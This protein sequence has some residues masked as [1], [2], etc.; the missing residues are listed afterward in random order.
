MVRLVTTAADRVAPWR[1]MGT[2]LREWRLAHG[3][4]VGVALPVEDAG[5]LLPEELA[6]AATL[7]EVR[8]RSWV[9]GRVAMRLTLTRLGLAAPPIT[10]DDRGAPVL[11]AGMV[12]SISHKEDLAVALVAA[13]DRDGAKIGVDVEKDEPRRLDI[14]RK[15]LRDEELAELARMPEHA[16]GSEVLLR[17]S[18]KEAL[19]K[20]LDPFVRRYV[21]FR[22]VAITPLAGGTSRVAWDL[23]EGE[24]PFHADVRWMREGDLILTTARVWPGSP[25]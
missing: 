18:A 17:F 1:P 19:Y 22:E 2:A 13:G 20:A 23:T 25:R 4:S 8:R 12:G 16:R 3:L 5:C 9:G 10:S 15:V 21:G 24:G 14:S 11:P 6:H 7:G